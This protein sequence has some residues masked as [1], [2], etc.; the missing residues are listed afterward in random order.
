MFG[1]KEIVGAVSDV[2]N[3][4]IGMRGFVSER[5]DEKFSELEEGIINKMDARLKVM[6]QRLLRSI[7]NSIRLQPSNVIKAIDER[8]ESRE[9]MQTIGQL[10]QR[11]SEVYYNVEKYPMVDSYNGKLPKL[12]KEGTKTYRLFSDT[13]EGIAKFK[14]GKTAAKIARHEVY[15]RFAKKY[16]IDTPKKTIVMFHDGK[17]SN[18][19][20]SYLFINNHVTKF[21]EFLESE[22]IDNKEE[23]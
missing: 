3:E 23:R 2:Q 8:E 4:V 9:R 17:Q 12:T 7:G 11:L 21:V 15:K 10:K 14:G 6:E 1:R 5:V 20:Y 18:S 19:V 22:Y 16:G 13:V